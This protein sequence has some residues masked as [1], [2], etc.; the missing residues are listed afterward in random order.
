MIQASHFSFCFVVV[1]IVCFLL[2]NSLCGARI[3]H[4]YGAG[5]MIK[6]LR[7]QI[8]AGAVKE[9]SSPELTLCAESYSVSVP[10]CVTPVARER[11]GS[12]YQKCRCQITPKDAYTLD[13]SK[14]E[15]ADYAAVQ[16]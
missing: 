12:F 6:S 11:P 2:S 7:V 13:P 3:A 8:P 1:A 5:L 9:F 4:W 14:S 10:P 16:A 15:W